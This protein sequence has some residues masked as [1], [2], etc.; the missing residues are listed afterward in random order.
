MRLWGIFGR[1]FVDLDGALDLHA[2]DALDA[3]VEERPAEDAPDAHA[4]SASR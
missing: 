1:P 2:L 3:E 4:G